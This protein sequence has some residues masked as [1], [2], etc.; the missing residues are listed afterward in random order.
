MGLRL[1]TGLWLGPELGW[2]RSGAAAGD[3]SGLGGTL[4]PPFLGAGPGPAVHALPPN[5]APHSLGT[6]GIVPSPGP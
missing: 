3:E 4:S 1:G 6:T 5:V 2:E